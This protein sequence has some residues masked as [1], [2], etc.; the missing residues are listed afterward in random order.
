MRCKTSDFTTMAA[1]MLRKSVLP[2]LHRELAALE[3]APC[4]E[5]RERLVTNVLAWTADLVAGR[6]EDAL[7]PARYALALE[8]IWLLSIVG[9]V[10][11][12]GKDSRFV[13]FLLR[14][15]LT[16]ALDLAVAAADALDLL[17]ETGVGDA[18]RRRQLDLVDM[19][20][21]VAVNPM[22]GVAGTA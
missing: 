11:N 10:P 16:R 1:D 12:P 15:D 14:P 20:A 19:M 13:D 6:D 8:T 18:Y 21:T 17:R 2:P 9:I 4:V 22:A 7:A 5:G 3:A